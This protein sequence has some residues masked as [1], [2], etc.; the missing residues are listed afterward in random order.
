[1]NV[2]NQAIRAANRFTA[3][4][5]ARKINAL[6][7]PTSS[8]SSSEVGNENIS[9]HSTK[10]GEVPLAN[11]PVIDISP[12]LNPGSSSEDRQ[13]CGQAIHEACCTYGFFYLVGHGIPQ[14][15]F[16][17]LIDHATRFFSKTNEEK[18]AISIAKSDN[19]LSGRGYQ[20]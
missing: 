6:R 11:L 4:Q 12:F 15:N 3:Q 9:S 13:L 8:S 16:D 20:R 10:P 14:E 5:V 17:Q 1:M 18:D 2:H 7:R 19:P